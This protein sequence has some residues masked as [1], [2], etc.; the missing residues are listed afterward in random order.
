M[1]RLPAAIS[2]AVLTCA[3]AVLIGCGSSAPE[4][5]TLVQ[6]RPAFTDID[7]SDGEGNRGDLFT[8]EAPLRK[9]GA[10]FGMLLG[11]TIT[12]GAHGRAGR[13]E[14]FEERI[15]NLV[16]RLP[17]GT[18]TATGASFYPRAVIYL[19]AEREQVRVIT[20]GSGAYI[21]AAGEVRTTRLKDGRYRQVF[22]FVN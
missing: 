3:A 2:A 22:V 19:P 5:F 18:I 15:A 1:R 11:Q 4:G 14:G 17:D 7:L 13:P 20:G 21:G 10:P 12:A 6:D 16:F 8:F 9:D